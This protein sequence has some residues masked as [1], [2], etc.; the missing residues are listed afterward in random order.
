MKNII[1]GWKSAHNKQ[2]FV[3]ET[4]AGWGVEH[5][6]ENAAKFNTI[7][8]CIKHWQSKH[9]VREDYAP[10]LLQH[11]LQFFNAKTGQHRLKQNEETI[12]R[13]RGRN[14]EL[15]YRST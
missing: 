4:A 12:Y 8:E 14:N 6:P 13:A 7:T 11:H 15:T 2:L 5:T 3:H 1:Y 9:A 10:L